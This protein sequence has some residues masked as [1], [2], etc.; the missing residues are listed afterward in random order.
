M[1]Q[2]LLASLLIAAAARLSAQQDISTAVVP[3]VGSVVG[4]NLIAWKT[5]LEL[6]NDSRAEVVVV[7]EPVGFEDRMII[8]TIEP[9]GVRRY[10]DL[11]GSAL[12]LDGVLTALFVRTS[13]RRS[14]L[15]RA[16][17][18]GRRGE[19]AFP[20]LFIPAT[21]V[22]THVPTRVLSGLAFSNEYRT[23]IGLA[24]LGPTP[25]Q[26]V[27]GLQRLAGRTLAVQRLTLPPGTLH[28]NSIQ[29]LFPMITKGGE[30]TVVVET[31][32]RDIHVYA[33]VLDNATNVA[34]FVQ[35]STGASLAFQRPPR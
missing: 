11:V 20:P 7:I 10:P 21:Y 13:A 32:A 29:T 35:P 23:N 27:L 16:T 9:G 22:V 1:R 24:N 30:F 28:H 2:M 18:Y 25:A 33:S 14:V 17:A 5:D 6:I 26:V 34:R 15:I 4:E 12:G 8:E 31:S 3:V 19:E